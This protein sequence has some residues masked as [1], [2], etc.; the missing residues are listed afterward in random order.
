[1][2]KLFQHDNIIKILDFKENGIFTDR[3]NKFNDTTYIVLEFAENK[4]LYDYI[5]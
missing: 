1:L 3:S 4:N 2:Q 5:Y